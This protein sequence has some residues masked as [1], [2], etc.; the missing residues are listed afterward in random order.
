MSVIN[1]LVIV[2]ISMIFLAFVLLIV[3]FIRNGLFNLETPM[4]S[5]E[6]VRKTIQRTNETIVKAKDIARK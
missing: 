5:A 1:I 6:R 4:E 2:A 3:H